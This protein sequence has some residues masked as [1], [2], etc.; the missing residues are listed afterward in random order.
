M[1]KRLPFNTGP[2]WGRWAS[3]RIGGER[4]DER[5]DAALPGGLGIKLAAD[6]LPCLLGVGQVATAQAQDALGGVEIPSRNLLE[7]KNLDW[8]R[9]DALGEQLGEQVREASGREHFVAVRDHLR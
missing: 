8:L 6:D 2:C 3:H 7:A 1:P 4:V 5:G 9:R